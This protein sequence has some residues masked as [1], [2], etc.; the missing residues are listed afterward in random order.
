[1]RVYL[2]RFEPADGRLDLATADALAPLAA[3]AEQIARIAHW[4]GMDRP[5]V[6]T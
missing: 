3:A 2:E 1:L 6:I 4:T 5:S